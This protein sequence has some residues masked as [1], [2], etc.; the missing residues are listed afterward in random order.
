M[1]L[2]DGKKV[3][4]EIKKEIALEV[5]KIVAS[6]KRPPHLAAVLVGHD[7][8]SE[9]YV[10]YKI[11]D[12]EAVGFRSSLI[13]YE[14]DVTEEELLSKITE[15][16]NDNEL[17][18]FI[19]QLPLPKH[20]SEQKVIEAIDPKKDVD[21]FHPVNV[22]RTVIGLPAY[23]SATPYGIMELI[24]R[25]NIEISG[26]NC[27]VVGRS[28]IVGRPVSILLSQKGVDATV[29]VAHSRTKNLEKI[30]AEADIL[31][32]ALG[33]PEF[34]KG[35]M[36]KEGAVVIDVGTTRIPSKE[37]KS[38]WKLKGDVMFS[39]VA[40]KC[41]FITPVPGGVGP[42]TRVSLLKNTLLAAKK[43]IY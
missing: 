31:V 12:C 17:D 34:V 25:Y 37:T 10:A 1:Q 41:S 18:G 16:N 7:G 15:L 35:H 39:E 36:V 24:R 11:K 8:G 4:E 27:V 40:E 42:M 28:Q 9:T 23:V 3:A 21:G 22:G 29:T 32:A 19:V 33:S 14:D 5:D 20:I 43:E 38:G 13:R 6:G 26:R 2:I 30:C